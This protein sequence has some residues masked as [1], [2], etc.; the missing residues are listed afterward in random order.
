ML[1][2]E[3]IAVCSQIHTKH[4]NTMCGQNAE[5]LV[6]NLVVHLVTAGLWR[7]QQPVILTCVTR[8]HTNHTR[9]HLQVAANALRLC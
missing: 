6:L 9:T 8:V 1:Y 7:V 5:F 2:S 3:I 4:I